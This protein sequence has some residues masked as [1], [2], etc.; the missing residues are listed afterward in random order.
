[1]GYKI[2]ALSHRK[3][4]HDYL[5]NLGADSVIDLSDFLAGVRLLG[6]D[7]V[8]CSFGH[9]KRS[10]KRD[11]SRDWRKS[12]RSIRWKKFL[13]SRRSYWMESSAAGT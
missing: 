7:L 12:L 4:N 9:G 3:S 6:I 1:M 11:P 8:Y 2:A 10:G 5:I 13:N